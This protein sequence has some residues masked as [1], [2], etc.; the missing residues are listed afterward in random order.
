MLKRKMR[1]CG[2]TSR[3]LAAVTGI[4]TFGVYLRLWGLKPWKLTE[5]L[6]ICC[7]YNT[8]QAETLFVREY[9]N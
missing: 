5:V 8:T 7:F 1:E 2:T 4:T 6:R 9:S 3:E